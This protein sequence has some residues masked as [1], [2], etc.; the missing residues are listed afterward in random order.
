MDVNIVLEVGGTE[1]KWTRITVFEVSD[2]RFQEG[3][4]KRLANVVDPETLCLALPRVGESARR[5]AESQ[6]IR[7]T[8]KEN[9]V[10]NATSGHVR[11][12]KGS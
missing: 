4:F 9:M 2:D 10:P 8:I 3:D 6:W 11:R 5:E 7:E 1:N 12:R